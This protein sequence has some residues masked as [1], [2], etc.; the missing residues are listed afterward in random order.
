MLTGLATAG[1]AD[2]LRKT[3]YLK[4][5]SQI[6]GGK[7][8]FGWEILARELGAVPE[9]SRNLTLEEAGLGSFGSALRAGLFANTAS[10]ESMIFDGWRGGSSLVVEQGIA[11]ATEIGVAGIE[12]EAAS[13]ARLAAGF[14]IT[15]VAIAATTFTVADLLILATSSGDD[16]DESGV[17]PIPV[18]V[19]KD[20]PSA[21]SLE[22]LRCAIKCSK[23]IKTRSWYNEC[24][25]Q[26][27]AEGE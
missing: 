13:A 14:S 9:A 22:V 1:Y 21:P 4:A 19:P 6:A 25:R 12:V 2:Y 17:R 8:L 26:C 18:P 27:L 15:V 10:S 7:P 5:G 20:P 16:D 23:F 24:L 3:K 11:S